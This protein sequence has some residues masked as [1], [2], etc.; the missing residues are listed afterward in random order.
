MEK[1]EN[2]P[3][4]LRKNKSIIYYGEIET[5]ETNPYRDFY[6]KEYGYRAAI[7]EIQMYINTRSY[8]I[9]TILTRLM[10]L[11]QNELT[12]MIDFVE[13][14]TQIAREQIITFIN[15]VEITK[16]IMAIAQYNLKKKID[17]KEVE[18]AYKMI[19]DTRYR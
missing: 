2:N 8:T 1:I 9:N 3:V 7:R 10:P 11:T 4:L 13:T 6:S 19:T 5:T 15:M 12:P 17:I 16:I 18:T 14:E